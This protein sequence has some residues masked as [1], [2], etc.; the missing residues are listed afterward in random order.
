MTTSE[1]LDRDL[2]QALTAL[3]SPAYP[4]YFD[5][6]LE[7]A[8]A[9]RQRARWAF[10]ERW[11]PMQVTAQRVAAP[12][13]IPVRRVVLLALIALLV[14]A[15]AMAG[16]SASRRLPSP[17]GVAANGALIYAAGGDIFSWTSEL[18]EPTRIVS[19]TSDDAG[20]AYS[21]DG[22]RIGFVR[23]AHD[24][25]EGV[26]LITADA[27]GSRPHTV[28]DSVD[29][30]GWD[31]SPSGRDLAVVVNG[32]A[33]TRLMVVD[34]EGRSAGRTLE[35]GLTD[36]QDVRWR[37]ADGQDLIVTGTD[38]GIPTIVAVRV[39]TGEV[40]ELF[41]SNATPIP[42][43]AVSPD[44][45]WVAATVYTG[46]VLLVIELVDLESRKA[47]RFGGRL[48]DLPPPSVEG[49]GSPSE[50]FPVWSPDGRHLAFV[51]YWDEIDNQTIKGQVFVASV[52]SDGADAVAIGPAQRMESGTN[53]FSQGYSPDGDKVV[54]WIDDGG[55][56]VVAPASG[57]TGETMAWSATEL[58]DWQRLALAP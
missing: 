48:P 53:A 38:H 21:R 23:V 35:T 55:T 22:T 43:T 8:T 11:L 41:R 37:P 54:M 2:T 9:R 18:A 15:L 19:G 34:A 6:A 16:L 13:W 32:A 39:A 36:L 20:P 10:P 29:L 4:E 30:R 5:D 1:R 12:M 14:G 31:W 51:R 56:I 52:A 40:R 3:A 26:S 46:H 33:G 42:A 7:R 25:S 58:P 57:G 17:F 45:R 28:L 50:G 49:A 47:D 44:G 24:G 27:D